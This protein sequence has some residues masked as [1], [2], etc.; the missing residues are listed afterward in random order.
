M[1]A[2][3]PTVDV[4]IKHRKNRDWCR[5]V[6]VATELPER[7]LHV[8]GLNEVR[9]RSLG[10][11][12]L[13]EAKVKILC[14]SGLA[15]ARSSL[16]LDAGLEANVLTLDGELSQEC[17]RGLSGAVALAIARCLH[18]ANDPSVLISEDWEEQ[19]TPLDAMSAETAS[20]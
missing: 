2:L 15:W 6:L 5:V 19:S 17:E 3:L 18:K 8:A 14:G 7:R 12:I 10:G 11:E 9:I 13:S 4:T 20:R 16:K 1:D